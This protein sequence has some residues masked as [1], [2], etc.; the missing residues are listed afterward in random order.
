M[1]PAG[2]GRFLSGT[3]EAFFGGL[4]ARLSSSSSS[5]DVRLLFDTFSSV[6]FDGIVFS[7][8]LR[9]VGP[10]SIGSKNKK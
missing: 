4:F 8:L 6:L 3:V 2:T 1:P 7:W 10:F 9:V 5:V